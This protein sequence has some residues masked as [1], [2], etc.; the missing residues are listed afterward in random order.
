V[1][2]GSESLWLGEGW[3][4]GI[5]VPLP[6]TLLVY[7]VKSPFTL[8]VIPGLTRN[9]VF[10]SWIPAFAGMTASELMQRSVGSTTL[11]KIVY[12]TLLF[13]KSSI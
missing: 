12:S 4:K 10:L 2:A 1:A 9:P 6:F 11:D 7:C 8:I 13:K 3:T 5:V